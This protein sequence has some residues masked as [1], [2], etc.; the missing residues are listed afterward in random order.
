MAE[1][2]SGAKQDVGENRDPRRAVE[3]KGG[4]PGIRAVAGQD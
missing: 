4:G 3:N 1:N 2:S